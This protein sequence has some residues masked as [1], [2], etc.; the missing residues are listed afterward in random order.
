MKISG[1]LGHLDRAVKQLERY[2][3]KLEQCPEEIDRRLSEI[4]ADEARSRYR[5]GVTV[6]A[7]DHGV[8]AEGDSVAFQEF[9]AGARIS[10]PFPDGADVSFEIRKGS[11]SDAHEGPY[12]QSGYKYWTF[13]G[14]TYT[15]I[16]PT[17]ALFYGME[18]AKEEAGRIAREVFDE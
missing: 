16:E 12:K 3:K 14:R 17:N 7:E 10:D 5:G 4:A 18:K 11:W 1:S 6:T 8:I 13:G 9:G 2:A 15:Y